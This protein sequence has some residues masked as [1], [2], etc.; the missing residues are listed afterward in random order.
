MDGGYSPRG[1]WAPGDWS[2]PD[3]LWKRD[4]D[5]TADESAAER[6]CGCGGEPEEEPW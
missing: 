5:L 3:P 4:A 6:F 1:D 2:V